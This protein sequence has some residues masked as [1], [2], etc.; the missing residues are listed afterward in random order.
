MWKYNELGKQ[1][2]WIPPKL[3]E[4]KLP[5]DMDKLV[6]YVM[7][8]SRMEGLL[9]GRDVLVQKAKDAHKHNNF[10]A[11][12]MVKWL[13][14]VIITCVGKENSD[15]EHWEFDYV[16][17][18][19]FFSDLPDKN[20]WL[21]LKVVSGLVMA[22]SNSAKRDS[23]Q[24]FFD[25]VNKYIKDGYGYRGVW[26]NLIN[27]HMDLT[28]WAMYEKSHESWSDAKSRLI[29]S[30]KLSKSRLWLLGHTLD[31]NVDK[32]NS[33]SYKLSYSYILNKF[34]GGCLNG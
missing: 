28:Y 15:K 23:L 25:T 3:E 33:E 11:Y 4:L 10:D 17:Y 34:L 29:S 32:L 27:A 18:R 6:S 31:S 21:W 30:T 20:F 8:L 7:G 2:T 22:Q 14:D 24:L 13:D 26:S 5:E 16:S 12:D 19:R 9:L 1:L